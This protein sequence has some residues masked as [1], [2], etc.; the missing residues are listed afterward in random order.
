MEAAPPNQAGDAP[1]LQ[2]IEAL[3]RAELDSMERAGRRAGRLRV[4]TRR[5]LLGGG[6]ATVGTLLYGS[7]AERLQPRIYR[8]EV[9]IASLAAALDGF[10]LCQISD[11]HSGP[12]VPPALIERGIRLALSLS[13]AAIVLTGDFVSDG[14]ENLGPA[15]PLLRRLQAPHGVFACLGNHDHWCGT[16]DRLTGGLMDAG[17]QV[18]INRHVQIGPSGS[19]LFL[20]GVDDAWSGEPDL[21]AAFHGAGRGPRLL[22]CH[23]PDYVTAAA[24]AGVDLQL[25]GHTHGG[26]VRIPGVGPLVRPHLGRLFPDGLCSIPGFAT[27]LYTNVGLGVI[28][29]AIRINCPPEI[30]LLTLRT[31]KDRTRNAVNRQN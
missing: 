31:S 9:R 15:L 29:P 24:Q 3:H 28:A 25:S 27:Q 22:L 12:L 1:A 18:L 21:D 5:A 17:L 20:G 26:Q 6:L 10:T 16:I 8:R 11:I 14:V 23:E 4:F 30:T 19:P 2:Q 13:P 7:E